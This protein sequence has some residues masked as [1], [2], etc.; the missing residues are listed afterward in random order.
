MEFRH[1]ESLLAIAEELHFGRAA[2]RL[3]LTQPAAAVP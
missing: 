3:H 1:P 2:A